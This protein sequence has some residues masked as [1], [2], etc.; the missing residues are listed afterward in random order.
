MRAEEARVRIK[1]QWDGVVT[2][3]QQ[4]TLESDAGFSIPIAF[5]Q[6]QLQV[7]R[8]TCLHKHLR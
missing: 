4:E 5:A 1:L 2:E 8:S 6:L 3:G 7:C